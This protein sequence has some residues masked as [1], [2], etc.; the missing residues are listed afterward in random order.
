MA[1]LVKTICE[2]V[3]ISNPAEYSL[4]DEET[5]QEKAVR[6]VMCEGIA[7]VSCSY[8][9]IVLLYGDGVPLYRDV[10]AAWTHLLFSLS[11]SV[12]VSL[13]LCLSLLLSCCMCR[14]FV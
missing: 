10:I 1:E 12:S 13:C 9:V 14:W 8:A 3:G 5:D 7:I 2:R 4:L 6:Q 11:V